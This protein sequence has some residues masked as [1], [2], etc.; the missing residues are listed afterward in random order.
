MPTKLPTQFQS[1][2]SA[3]HS[4][5]TQ[6]FNTQYSISPPSSPLRKVSHANLNSQTQYELAL[7]SLRSKSPIQFNDLYAVEKNKMFRKNRK[8][9]KHRRVSRKNRKTRS[10]RS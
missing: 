8:T 6:H 3:L 4:G 1:A 5:S 9:R 2:L 7:K 10:N